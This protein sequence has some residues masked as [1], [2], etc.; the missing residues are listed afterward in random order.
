MPY[1]TCFFQ[2]TLTLYANLS[3]YDNVL[4][5]LQF[6]SPS[7]L[8]YCMKC[9][10]VYVR[11]SGWKL[12]YIS[13]GIRS[14]P[15][16]TAAKHDIFTLLTARYFFHANFINL[17]LMVLYSYLW[18]PESRILLGFLR[19]VVPTQGQTH[20]HPTPRRCPL[21]CEFALEADARSIH[22]IIWVKLCGD[23][24]QK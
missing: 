6:V 10:T 13:Y 14:R 9:F 3:K 21:G 1:D 17:T 15:Q 11:T 12:P 16:V 23:N 22:V 2:T 19:F 4:R 8:V 5:R 24:V 18:I 7:F 20:P